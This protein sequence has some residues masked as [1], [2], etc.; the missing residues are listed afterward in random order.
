VALR[1]ARFEDLD[2]AGRRAKTG[3]LLRAF[4]MPVALLLDHTAQCARLICEELGVP[5]QVVPIEEAFNREADAA[6][7]M[8]GGR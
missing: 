3:E 6:R 4:Y 2:D 1:A 8:V 7:T 5:F